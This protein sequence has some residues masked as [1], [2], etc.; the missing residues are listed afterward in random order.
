MERLYALD[1]WWW[2]SLSPFASPSPLG[3]CLVSKLKQI[4]DSMGISGVNYP[5]KSASGPPPPAPR[6]RQPPPPPPRPAPYLAIVSA[7]VLFAAHAS[8]NSRALIYVYAPIG[9]PHTMQENGS[10]PRRA[11]ACLAKATAPRASR[12]R[13][14]R[15]KSSTVSRGKGDCLG[16]QGRTTGPHATSWLASQA[17]RCKTSWPY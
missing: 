8:A 1:T 2:V 10:P 16:S 14:A 11:N 5:V 7:P 13:A 6:A 3:R 12:A 9:L 15:T 17:L 4:S